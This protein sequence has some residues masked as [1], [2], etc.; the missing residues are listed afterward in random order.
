MVFIFISVVGYFKMVVVYFNLKIFLL[1]MVL[2]KLRG[3][4]ILKGFL[5]KNKM[6]LCELLLVD[7]L[8][9]Y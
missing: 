1:Y 2:Y 3:I 4:F 9:L 7:L 5:I 6:L 8:V